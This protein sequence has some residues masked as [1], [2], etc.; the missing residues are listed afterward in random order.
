MNGSGMPIGLRRK[1][2]IIDLGVRRGICVIKIN[3]VR[4]GI[5]DIFGQSIRCCLKSIGQ[6]WKLRMDYVIYA[7]SHLKGNS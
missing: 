3:F 5:S 1:G 7:E 6:E 2:Y 4:Q